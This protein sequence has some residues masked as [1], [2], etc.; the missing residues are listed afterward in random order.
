MT[1]IALFGLVVNLW[2]AVVLARAGAEDL[3]TRSAFVHM[4]GDTVSS[5]AIVVGGLFVW[6]YGWLWVDPALSVGVACIVGWWGLRLIRESTRILLE[7]MPH[8]L[9]PGELTGAILET[10]PEASELH[11]LHV[12]EI[13]SGYVCLTAHLVVEDGTISERARIHEDVAELLRRRFGVGHVTLQLE[14]AEALARGTA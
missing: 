11:D 13:T 3:N 12:W 6:R 7:L 5:V 10:V 14:P 8:G 4:L 1:L 2:T 9:D